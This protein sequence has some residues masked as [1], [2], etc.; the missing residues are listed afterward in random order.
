MKALIVATLLVIALPLTC[1][2]YENRFE[3]LLA[4]EAGELDYPGGDADYSGGVFAVAYTRFLAPIE[5]DDSPY[6]VREFLQHPS[7]FWVALVGVATEIDDNTSND[8]IE[9]TLSTLFVGGEFYINDSDN[10]TGLGIMISSQGGEEELSGGLNEDIDISSQ[11]IDFSLIQYLNRTIR[12]SVT[13][14]TGSTEYEYSSGGKYEYDESALS[15]SVGALVENILLNASISFGE[16]DWDGGSKQD[17]DSLSFGGTIYIDQANSIAAQ[18]ATYEVESSSKLSE[19]AITGKHYF[20]DSKYLSGSLYS[21][22]V[23][24]DSSNALGWDELSYMGVRAI[25]GLYF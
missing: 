15:V 8:K 23:D 17:V 25:F 10:A 9:D 13:Y 12:F 1:F 20:D 18:Y 2:A 7:N 21:G 14:T 6:G 11:V 5:T 19:I 16:R 3:L 24:Y 4:S 22:S